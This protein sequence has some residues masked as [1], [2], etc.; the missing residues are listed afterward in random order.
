MR[1]DAAVL[2]GLFQAVEQVESRQDAR[3]LDVMILQAISTHFTCY[4]T[5]KV[6]E[7]IHKPPILLKIGKRKYGRTSVVGRS[8]RTHIEDVMTRKN[9]LLRNRSIHPRLDQY[10]LTDRL[11][12]LRF[13]GPRVLVLGFQYWEYG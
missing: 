3:A 1:Q 10:M 13:C 8:E 5:T 9:R 7:R 2:P 6:V 11:R 4:R 12:M